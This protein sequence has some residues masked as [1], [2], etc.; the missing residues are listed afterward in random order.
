MSICKFNFRLHNF[1]VKLP[2]RCA[3]IARYY[4]NNRVS[5]S[6][7]YGLIVVPRTFD[8]L[9]TNILPRSEASRASFKNIKFPRGNYTLN[10]NM[11]DR[12][13]GARHELHE[14]EASQSSLF[15]CD[16]VSPEKS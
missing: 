9:K 13:V 6:R 4:L 12:S 8:V 14:S 3:S 1:R 11:A 16:N 7:N 5:L 10:A 15:C 2:R